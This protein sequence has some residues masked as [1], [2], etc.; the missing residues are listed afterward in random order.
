M[1]QTASIAL[2]GRYLIKPKVETEARVRRRVLGLNCPQSMYIHYIPL[3]TFIWSWHLRVLVYA[4]R[5]P[6]K[7]YRG[8]GLKKRRDGANIALPHHPVGQLP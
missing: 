8:E 2:K 6:R 4:R 3:R 1:T 5:R 7:S